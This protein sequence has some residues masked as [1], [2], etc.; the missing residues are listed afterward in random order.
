MTPD[1]PTQLSDFPAATR[2]PVCAATRHLR[3]PTP[4][5]SDRP[6]RRKFTA[7]DELRILKQADLAAGTGQIGARHVLYA[8]ALSECADNPTPGRLARRGVDRNRARP[9][10]W[11][12]NRLF[13]RRMSY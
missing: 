5:T 11:R 8:S 2:C 10:R 9:I 6:S 13:K 1:Q 7:S 3:Q 4:K 12:Q